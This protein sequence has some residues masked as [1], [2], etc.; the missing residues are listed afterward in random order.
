MEELSSRGLTRPG[1]FHRILVLTWRI[2]I[3][4]APSHLRGLFHLVIGLEV[5]MLLLEGVNPCRPYPTM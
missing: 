2:A 5:P 1:A 4:L 3:G